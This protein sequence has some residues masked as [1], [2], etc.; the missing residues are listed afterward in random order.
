MRIVPVLLTRGWNRL[1][2]AVSSGYIPDRRIRNGLLNDHAIFT[3]PRCSTLAESAVSSA[4]A[5]SQLEPW[6]IG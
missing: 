2:S 5:F 1:E 6:S 3:H 4:L